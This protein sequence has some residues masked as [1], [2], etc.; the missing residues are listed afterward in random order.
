MPEWI[1][2]QAAVTL[3]GEFLVTDDGVVNVRCIYGEDC[4]QQGG[5]RAQHVVGLVLDG[6]ARDPSSASAPY[7]H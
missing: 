1:K 6:M 2:L 7:W 3:D 5:L 4:T